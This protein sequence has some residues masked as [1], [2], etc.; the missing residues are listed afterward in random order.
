MIIIIVNLPTRG[1]PRDQQKCLLMEGQN[2]ASVFTCMWP[3]VQQ[4]VC[5]HEVSAYM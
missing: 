1:F 2:T 5:L 4:I 3:E